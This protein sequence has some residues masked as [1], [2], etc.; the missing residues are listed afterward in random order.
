MRGEDFLFPSLR[1]HSLFGGWGHVVE[2]VNC[3]AL[4]AAGHEKKDGCGLLRGPFF[5]GRGIRLNRGGVIPGFLREGEFGVRGGD[6]LIGKG[7]F[8]RGEATKEMVHIH[9]EEE[10]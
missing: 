2:S 8:L 10:S 9:R 7:D 4:P 3:V 1:E 5:G 6:V